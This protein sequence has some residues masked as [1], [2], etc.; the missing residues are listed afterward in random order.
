LTEE[1]LRVEDAKKAVHSPYLAYSVVT[2]SSVYAY[3][4]RV[5]R[6]K[7]EMPTE[8]VTQIEQQPEEPFKKERKLRK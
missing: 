4:L 2:D 5:S 6:L 3:S 8:E 1:L 7:S